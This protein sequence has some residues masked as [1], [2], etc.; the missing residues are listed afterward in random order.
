M[1]VTK[2]VRYQ[3]LCL[4]KLRIAPYRVL[5]N[6]QVSGEAVWIVGFV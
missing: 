6:R 4:R 5:V 2:A 1:R 3:A